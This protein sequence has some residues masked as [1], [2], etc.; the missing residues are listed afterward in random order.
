MIDKV[1]RQRLTEIL[2]GTKYRKVISERLNVH[3]NTV[4]NLLR[5]N[6]PQQTPLTKRVELELLV[7]AKEVRDAQDLTPDQ[8]DARAKEIKKDLL[9]S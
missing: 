5:E 7:Y 6:P 4:S 9:N 3:P 2:Q 8:I 1:M